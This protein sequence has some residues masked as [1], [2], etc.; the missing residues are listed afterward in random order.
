MKRLIVALTLCIFTGA[1]SATPLYTLSSDYGFR[2]ATWT[3][4]EIFTVGANDIT[5]TAL[6]AYDNAQNG[7]ISQGGIAVGLYRESDGSLLGSTHVTSNDTLDG[8]FRYANISDIVLS[9]GQQ[10]R[11]VAANDSDPYNIALNTFSFD[12][13]VSYD[14]STLCLGGLQF[15]T[16]FSNNYGFNTNTAYMANLQFGS[17]PVGTKTSSTVP[18]PASIALL[19]LGMVGMSISRLKKQNLARPAPTT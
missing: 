11:V 5:V 14:G 2:N 15:C 13:A 19:G 4:G 7:F 18:E 6:G 17:T 1:A 8:F 12:P 3:L 9:A 16:P 10:Y